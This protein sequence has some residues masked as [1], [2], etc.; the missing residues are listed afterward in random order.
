MKSRVF[1]IGG[2][3]EARVLANSLVR[4][5]YSVTA[6][7]ENRDVCLKLAENERIEVY[8]GDGSRPTILEEADIYDADIAIA[9]TERDEDN[10]VISELCKKK[11]NV[12]RMVALILDPKKT[13][14]FYRM[15]IDAVICAA[16]MIASAL[17]EQA[18]YDEVTTAITVGDRRINAIQVFISKTS[19][20]V[21]KTVRQVGLPDDVIVGCIVR[22]GKNMIPHESLLIQPNDILLLL[23]AND[24]ESTVIRRLTRL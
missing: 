14:F 24:A 23:T 17:E 8:Q 7:N 19:S 3:D 20:A 2:D 11:Y 10:L 13:D 12:K 5:G 21:D 6:I 9:L 1:I 22:D 15:G 18:F 16:S 4:K